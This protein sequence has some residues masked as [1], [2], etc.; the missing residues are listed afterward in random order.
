MGSPAVR[1]V[2][3]PE[4]A[5]AHSTLSRVD[6]AD[7]FVVDEL[8]AERLTAE[9]WAR[10]ALQDAPAELRRSLRWGWS[11]LG[12]RLGPTRA[13]DRILGWELRRRT[14]DVALLAA[15]SR[16]GMPAEVL[17]ERRTGSLLFCTFVEHGNPLARVLWAAIGPQHRQV[18][19][20]LLRRVA[21]RPAR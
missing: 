2:S 9:G 19:A 14:P 16:L 5:R 10:A 8:P 21:C 11:A 12:L 15:G 13:E 3:V 4:E 20:H 7:A 1:Q 17:F 18:V 6:Y